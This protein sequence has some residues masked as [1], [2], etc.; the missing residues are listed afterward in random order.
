MLGNKSKRSCTEMSLFTVRL[1]C[2]HRNCK[3][4][5][6]F[7]FLRIAFDF[8]SLIQSYATDIN[9]YTSVF[10]SFIQKFLLDE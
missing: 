3:E 5:L 1:Q 10:S 7:F 2:G 6:F 9:C 8:P 4:V